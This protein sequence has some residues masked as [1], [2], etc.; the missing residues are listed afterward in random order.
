MKH[1]L[2]WQKLSDMGVSDKFIRVCRSLYDR[3]KVSV[4]TS[5]GLSDPVDV[6]EGVLQGEIMSPLLFSLF[7]SNLEKY[8]AD[9]GARGIPIDPKNEITCIA[10]ADD[11]VLLAK[12][13]PDLRR[14]IK[15]ASR[16]P[17]INALRIN[18]SKSKILIFQKGRPKRSLSCRNKPIEIVKEFCYLGCTFI[19]SGLYSKQFLKAKTSTFQAIDAVLNIIFA[20]RSNNWSSHLHLFNALAKSVLSYGSE[21]WG[22]RHVNDIN[23]DVLFQKIITPSEVHPPLRWPS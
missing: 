11:L 5:V 13:P 17:E 6:K 4:C 16:Y 7:I 18:K 9:N 22:I 8:L 10:Y 15:I 23:S 12:N 20:T 14:K 1:D 2:L 3:A 19:T 21:I